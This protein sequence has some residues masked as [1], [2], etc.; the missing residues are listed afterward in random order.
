MSISNSCPHC[1]QA[2]KVRRNPAPTVDIIICTSNREVVLIQRRNPPHGWA[3][4]GGFVDYGESVEQAAIREAREETGLKVELE[5]LLGV[6]S[7][8]ER[9]PRQ[10][11][12]SIV[13][14]VFVKDQPSLQAGDDARE[15]GLFPL[16]QLPD[17]AF[18]HEQ[19]LEDF[20]HWLKSTSPAKRIYDGHSNCKQ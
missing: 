11:T 12:L 10:H 14:I 16:E 3:L 1:G 19:I 8:P 17:L 20:R 4:P 5:V 9:D 6:Y 7:H 15:A 18:D 13:F 2:L